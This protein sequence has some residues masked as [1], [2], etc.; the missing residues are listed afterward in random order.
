MYGEGR[1][2]LEGG[3]LD[4][5]ML[6]TDF[7]NNNVDKLYN[8]NDKSPV[9]C[10]VMNQEQNIAIVGNNIGI[11][12]TYEVNETKYL[13]IKKIQYH[14]KAINYLF[15]SDELNA[16]ASC[17]ED[18]YVNIYSIP[19]CDIIHSFEID[20]PEFVLLSGKP[21]PVCVI[22]SKKNKKLLSYGV[23][24]HFINGIEV[25]NKPQYPIIYTNKH[26]RDYLIYS[27]KGFIYIKSLPNLESYNI[28][29]LNTNKN[30]D[31]NDIY[32]QFYRNKNGNEQLYALDQSIQTLYIIGDSEN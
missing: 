5:L 2:L 15:L 13:L 22:Y 1:Y 19:N 11:I 10:I 3:Y 23:N 16:F 30:L 25:E 6:L 7:N 18:Q 24:G 14:Q 32:L 12:Y 9:T 26:F 17:S 29:K 4:G 20:E 21:L 8:P 27:I 31:L 28:I